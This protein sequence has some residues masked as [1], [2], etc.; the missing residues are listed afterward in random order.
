MPS[1]IPP[2]IRSPTGAHSGPALS[3]CCLVPPTVNDVPDRLSSDVVANNRTY[4]EQLAP[5]R[6]GLPVEFFQAGGSA[7]TADELQAVGKVQGRRVLQLACSMGD[8]A[9]TLAQLGADVTAVDIAPS[10]LETGRAKAQAL[11][12]NVTFVEHDMMTLDRDFGEFDLVYISS[13]GLCWSP[14][15]ITWAHLVSGWLRLG[16]TLVISEHHPLWE[17]LTVD[18]EDT[19]IVSGNYFEAGRDGYPDPVKAPQVTQQLGVPGVVPRSFVWGIGAV[20]SAVLAAGLTLRSLQEFS[21]PELYAGLGSHATGIP[22][23]YLLR[24]TR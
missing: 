10:H 8:D 11:G 20:V 16:G 4:W 1:A 15:I 5:H 3:L 9:L 7:L 19:L 23:T 14:D 12:L 2:S 6:R 17:V 13:G 22:A 24:A 18:S 21:E